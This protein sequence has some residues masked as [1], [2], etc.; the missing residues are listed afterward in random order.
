[1]ACFLN[2]IS[3]CNFFQEEAVYIEKMERSNIPSGLGKGNYFIGNKKIIGISI[4]Q[5][6]EVEKNST[7]PRGRKRKVNQGGS[8][9]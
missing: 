6:V 3:G 1:M 5:E 8:F 4:P 9:I 7:S 2:L